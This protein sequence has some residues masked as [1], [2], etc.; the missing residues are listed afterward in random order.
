MTKRAMVVDNDIFFVEFLSD[1]LEK[2]GYDVIKAYDGKDGVDRLGSGDVDFIFVDIVMPKMGGDEF[3]HFVREKF[4]DPP[5]LIIAVSGTIT[6]EP[7]RVGKMAADYYIAK[8]PMEKMEDQINKFMDTLE[9][10]ISA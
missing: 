5:F 4:P 9:A 6:E 1:L 10:Q 8:G 3:I 2:R 7:H